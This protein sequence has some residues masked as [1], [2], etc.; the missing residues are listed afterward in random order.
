MSKKTWSKLLWENAWQVEDLT[1]IRLGFCIQT[2]NYYMK[3]CLVLDTYRW[4]ELSDKFP[5]LVKTLEN[6]ARL[7]S[8]ASRLSVTT[9]DLRVYPRVIEFARDAT[10]ISLKIFII[11][12]CKALISS[13][14]EDKCIMTY[15]PMTTGCI[16]CSQKIQDMF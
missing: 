16:R 13:L 2:M 8:H 10:S 7:V 6:K 1:G 4:W 9:L 14:L 11:L 12:F 5:H 3:F 15:M